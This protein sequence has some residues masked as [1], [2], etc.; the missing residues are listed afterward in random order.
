MPTDPV[1]EPADLA[2]LGPVR[3]LDVRDAATFALGHFP[4]AVR[5][6]CV[7]KTLSELMT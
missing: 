5:V 6:L 4:D 7:L 1:I 3:L 2:T